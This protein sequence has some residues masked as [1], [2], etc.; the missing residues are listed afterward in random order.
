MKVHQILKQGSYTFYARRAY[1][2]I[3]D[4][5]KDNNVTIELK[6]DPGERSVCLITSGAY[7]DIT[8]DDQG[9][10]IEWYMHKTGTEVTHIQ[11]EGIDL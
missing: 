5:L 3:L 11:N 2:K 8:E 4:G 7:A 1:E 6:L 9:V 10:R